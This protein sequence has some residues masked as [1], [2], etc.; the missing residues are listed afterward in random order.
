[1]IIDI[2]TYTPEEYKEFKESNFYFK[3]DPPEIEVKLQELQKKLLV[4]QDLTVLP[5]FKN[6]LAT[7]AKSH[8]LARLK[9]SSD[10]ID[11]LEVEALSETAAENFLKRYFRNENP[12]IGASFSG[13][14]QFKVTEVLSEYFK[15]KSVGSVL[16]LDD[17]FSDKDGS[18]SITRESLLSYKA[19]LKEQG[20][21]KEALSEVDQE[22]ILEK[23]NEECELL[24]D[25]EEIKNA[26]VLFLKFLIYI[27]ILQGWRKDKKLNVV[28]NIAER[29]LEDK[30]Y[31][32][33]DLKSLLESAFL[34]C[35]IGN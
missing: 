2:K 14:L 29:L 23:I 1:M 4:D 32:S 28:I 21:E 35:H 9:G 5:T 10:Y 16:S 27:T 31:N 33:F 18:E 26:D 17:V 7:Y 22:F 19:F 20:L 3:E 30:K 13:V 8:L 15:G 11:P 24:R 34:D 6:T 25:I 12:I